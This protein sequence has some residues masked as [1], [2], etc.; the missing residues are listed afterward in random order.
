VNV[1]V[2]FLPLNDHWLHKEGLH[3]V[4][5]VRDRPYLTRFSE[6]QLLGTKICISVQQVNSC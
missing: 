2:H 5:S 4:E 3:G 6:Q 1:L